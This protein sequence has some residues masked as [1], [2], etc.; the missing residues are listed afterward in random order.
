MSAIGQTVNARGGLEPDLRFLPG[1]RWTPQDRRNDYDVTNTV[2]DQ[3][4]QS[5]LSAQPDVAGVRHPSSLVL[6]G[7]RSC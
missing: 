3:R 1:T 7:L 5:Q 4:E 2:R 6:G